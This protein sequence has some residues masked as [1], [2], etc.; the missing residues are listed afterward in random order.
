MRIASDDQLQNEVARLAEQAITM[1][2]AGGS[3]T[4]L[5]MRLLQ[6]LER[7]IEAARLRPREHDRTADG[8]NNPENVE[9]CIGRR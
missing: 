1:T 5:A 7:A 3:D 6:Q 2:Q 4:Q 8:T 9:I